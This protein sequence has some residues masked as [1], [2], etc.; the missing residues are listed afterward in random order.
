MEKTPPKPERLHVNMEIEKWGI[1]TSS[2][3]K[4]F[5][6]L[7]PA[8][9]SHEVDLVLFLLHPLHIL[10]QTRRCGFVVGGLEAEQLSQAGSVGVIL[11]H[12][13]LNVGAKFLPELFIVL[14]FGDL[15]DHVQSLAHQLL[16]NDLMNKGTNVSV[17]SSSIAC[18]VSTLHHIIVHKPS[19]QCY[20]DL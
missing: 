13:Q 8:G 5:K 18:T 9:S 2:E 6:H 14:F 4:T 7:L 20:F 15:L 19:N 16:A 3:D 1:I 12:T 10:L 11:N 17:E